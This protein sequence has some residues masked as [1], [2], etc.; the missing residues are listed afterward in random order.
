MCTFDVEYI[1]QPEKQ[2][3][4]KKFLSAYQ[5]AIAMKNREGAPVACLTIDRRCMRNYETA[6]TSSETES[7]VCLICARRFFKV[8]EIPAE[9]IEWIRLLRVAEAESNGEASSFLNL[10]AEQIQKVFGLQ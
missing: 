8:N 4:I 2:P 3:E 5:E 1:R 6:L 7:L 9:K 10:K